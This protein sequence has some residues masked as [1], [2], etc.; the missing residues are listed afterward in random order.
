M[1]KKSKRD[2]FV[3]VTPE[4]ERL[5]ELD[6]FWIQID[7]IPY[8]W[9]FSYL[10]DDESGEYIPV[11]NELARFHEPI[12]M[13]HGRESHTIFNWFAREL[14]YFGFR[15]LFALDASEP[16]DLQ[17]SSDKLS[18]VVSYIKEISNAHRISL[19][20]YSTAGIVARNYTKFRHGDTQIRILAMID[21]PHDRVQ[22]LKNLL[23]VEKEVSRPDIQ[24][25]LEYLQDV[26]STITEKEL[27]Y[28]T[29]INI[30]GALWARDL[31]DDEV[32]FIP[33]SDA[34]NITLGRTQ[35]RVHKH[36]VTFRVLKNF[37]IPNLAIFKIRL[38]AISNVKE[39]IGFK[40]H[41]KGHTTQRYPQRGLIKI[42]EVKDEREAFLPKV[43]VI[44]FSNFFSVEQEKE[45]EIAI[46]SF[47]KSGMSQKT[48]GKVETTINYTQLPNVEYFT[49]KGSSEERIDFAV[50]SYIP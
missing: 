2:R 17:K 11:G 24:K 41:Y 44:I 8:L 6:H 46:Y 15:M 22:Y 23:L 45:V 21:S 34:V 3:D 40:I 26:N 27:Y 25:E 16:V 39:P 36:K 42:P 4:T 32:R 49:L 33:L 5:K 14:W 20:A 30:G 12:L 48:T 1:E 35:L 31:R 50:Y 43:P 10:S 13:L 38:L 18:Q 29:N 19:V 37:F 7:E 28:L 47:T 9:R